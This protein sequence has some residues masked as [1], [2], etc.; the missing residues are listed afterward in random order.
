MLFDYQK[1]IRMF[2]IGVFVTAVMTPVVH[3]DDDEHIS[4]ATNAKHKKCGACSNIP[5]F[6]DRLY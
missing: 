3:A 6:S 1:A 5:T 2:A 4:T